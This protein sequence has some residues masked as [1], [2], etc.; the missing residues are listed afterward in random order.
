[1]RILFT[2]LGYKP[3]YRFGGPVM[4]VSALA[5]HLVVKGHKV[6]VF[7]NNSN[8]DQY[9]DVPV[10]Q[11]VAVDGVEVWYFEKKDFFK[12]WT[13]FIPY[14]SK[15]IG[16]MY[17][18][19]ISKELDR[20][21]PRIDVV[22][23][24]TVF[25]YPTLAA[26]QAAHRW[27]KPHFYHQRG[28]MLPSMMKFRYYKKRFYIDLVARR[29]MQ[30]ATTLIALNQAEVENFR[31]LG[32]T[33]PCYIVPNGVE[34]SA[35]R[36]SPRQTSE[37]LWQIPPEAKVILY[38]GRL[39]PTKGAERLLTAFMQIAGDFPRLLL[40]LAGP[41]EWGYGNEFTRRVHQAGLRERVIFTGMVSGEAKLDRHSGIA[42]AGM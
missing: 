3:A 28:A 38:L 34:V 16:W 22:D 19:L 9:L 42:V 5:E 11:P 21:L 40:V 37:A 33:T 12:R 1:L 30:K 36:Q 20:L 8:L 32:V 17:N 25:G 35:Y 24:N 4:S 26:A 15:S 18:P 39:H 7:A 13:P 41:D 14:L 27:G 23:T 10:N 2:V 31:A 29:V 6:I